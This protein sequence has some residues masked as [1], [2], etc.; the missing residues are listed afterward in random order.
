MDTLILTK[1][2]TK[3]ARAL[4]GIKA[5]DLAEMASISHDTVR[6]FE[7]GRS[8]TLSVTNQEAITSA[9]ENA[10]IQFLETG[11]VSEGDGVVLKGA[12]E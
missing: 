7:S 4:L 11:G 2:M 10:G 5:S 1:E 8:K 9:L 6:S 3:A 12:T